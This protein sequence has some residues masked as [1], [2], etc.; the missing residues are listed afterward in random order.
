MIPLRNKRGTGREAQEAEVKCGP[1][2]LAKIEVT[3]A[4]RTD[5]V[6]RQR[7]G[8]PWYAIALLNLA[9]GRVH[10]SSPHRHLSEPALSLTAGTHLVTF[11]EDGVF[12]NDYPVQDGDWAG[13]DS[14]SLPP[15]G[16]GFSFEI[17]HFGGVWYHSSTGAPTTVPIAAGAIHTLILNADLTLSSGGAM[18]KVVPPAEPPLPSLPPLSPPRPSPPPAPPP[19]PP[20][21][22][23]PPPPPSP[24]PMPPMP[25]LAP[26]AV[27][28]RN[29]DE[30]RSALTGLA[31]EII[32]ADGTYTGSG[33]A[34]VLQINKDITIRAQN[35]G[36][37]VLD[38]ENTR[39]VISIASGTVV[40]DGLVITRG[41]VNSA[42][43]DLSTCQY[44]DQFTCS[45]KGGGGV[46]ISGGTST[47]MACQILSNIAMKGSAQ[48][49]FGGGMYITGQNTQVAIRS[50][51]IS[52]NHAY[53]HGGGMIIH[54]GVVTV[55]QTT[56]SDNKSRFGGGVF[57]YGGRSTFTSCEISFNTANSNGGRGGG[58]L[59]EGGT[60]TFTSCQILSNRVW[61]EYYNFA[62]GNGGG[63]ANYGGSVTM[64]RTLVS[65]NI[66]RS[67]S[68]ISPVAGLTYYTL[69]TPPGYWLPNSDCVANRGPCPMSG[70]G[71]EHCDAALCSVTSGT[72]SNSWTPTHCPAP[73]FIQPCEWQNDACA[74]GSDEC[75]LGKKVFFVA[76]FPVDVPV[77]PYPCVAGYLGSNESAHQISSD[78]AGKCPG[79]SYC[80]TA[81]TLTAIPCTPGSYCPEGASAPLPC[82]KGTYSNATNLT[83][84][85]ECAG[86]DPG[87]FAPTGSTQQTTCAAGTIAPMGRSAACANCPAG[88]FQDAE[89]A[90]ACK[91]CTD[92]YYCAEGAAA[93]LPC[94]SGT[95]KPKGLSSA[96]TSVNECL[97]CPKGTFCPVGSASATNC[98]AGTYSDQLQQEVCTACNAGT[99]QDVEG[100]TACKACEAGSYCPPG[101]AAPLPCNGGTYSSANSNAALADCTVVDAGYFAT[102][103]STAQAACAKGT[104]TDASTDPKDKCTACAGGT[105]QDGE[106]A[107]ACKACDAGSYCPVGAV[108]CDAAIERERPHAEPCSVTP[109]CC[110]AETIMGL[111]CSVAGRASAVQCW[112]VLERD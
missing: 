15:D 9:A 45:S 75:L 98:S 83:S 17:I 96:M 26:G 56:I 72:A 81:V 36:Q 101:A 112:H 13:T 44:G 54:D 90:T 63:I 46:Y 65:G 109:H 8:A 50:S 7:H 35:P 37:A 66:A 25:P 111:L 103:G 76:Y 19:S 11:T 91:V 97:I 39:R 1:Q 59:L 102:T 23:P 2:K 32:L 40:L 108:S 70:P 43:E 12:P 55:E 104:Y 21:L 20:P 67:G 51:Q 27:Y 42:Q 86:A 99:Y 69:P 93:A 64:S 82:A 62:L 68:N 49:M 110:R 78:C 87:H 48:G 84:A 29:G 100:A 106:G 73:V 88:M 33:D 53:E 30:L 85:S 18:R 52:G 4:A 16:D 6:V 74:T 34:D 14:F 60:S 80:P 95:T 47:F 107:T 58:V 105:Y 10:A 92:G 3:A 94:P 24:P 71:F 79:G 28:V 77:F 89:G 22:S 31:T 61:L 5:M 41:Y 38:G 57:H